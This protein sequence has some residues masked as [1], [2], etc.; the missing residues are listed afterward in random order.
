MPRRGE[1]GVEELIIALLRGCDPNEVHLTRKHR[2]IQHETF[3]CNQRY[4]R[5]YRTLTDEAHPFNP[6]QEEAPC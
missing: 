1:K 3:F 4:T 6:I 5:L 2:R